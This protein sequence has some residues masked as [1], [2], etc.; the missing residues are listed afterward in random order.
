M[1]LA[2]SNIAWERHDD[3]R[4][5]K[6]LENYRVL[7]IEIAPTKLWPEWKGASYQKAS[8]YKKKMKAC[9][10]H[11]PAMQAVLFGKPELQIFNKESH[12]DFF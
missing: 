5:L 12:S 2:A 10:F 1:K 6:L 11:L 3:P 4:I 9:G 7:G 8:N